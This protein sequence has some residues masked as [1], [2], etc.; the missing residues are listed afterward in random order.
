[1]LDVYPSIFSCLRNTGCGN[2]N[3]WTTKLLKY[4]RQ[5]L[6]SIRNYMAL[7]KCEI[8]FAFASTRTVKPVYT[9]HPRDLKTDRC[10]G[11]IWKNLFL[12]GIQV[13]VV[14]R[15]SLTQVWLSSR[16]L[17]PKMTFWSRKSPKYYEVL[18][19]IKKCR[20]I[21]PV[22]VIGIFV[23]RVRFIRKFVEKIASA[24]S[25]H[26]AGSVWKKF[27][28]KIVRLSLFTVCLWL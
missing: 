1:M 5:I 8:C 26:F 18:T 12:G 9:D 27:V 22:I 15:R 23:V 19:K 25:W 20:S 3:L 6:I 21:I 10:S 16:N 13:V 2:D 4:F 17:K 7:W 28:L 24:H 11:L 14:Q